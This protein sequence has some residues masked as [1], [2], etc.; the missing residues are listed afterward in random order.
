MPEKV[1]ENKLKFLKVLV[2]LLFI[3]LVS[4]LAY[5][6]LVQTQQFSTLSEQNRIRLVP[7]PAKRGE[8]L[9]H[10]GKV[11]V[12]DRPVYSVSIAY[13]GLKDQDPEK[14]AVKLAS[15]LGMNAR[16]IVAAVNDKNIRK[17]EPI[18]I[19]TDVPIDVVTKIEENRADL[20]GVEVNVEPMR[21]YVY[22]DFMPHALGYVREITPN[23]LKVHKDEGYSL[24]DRFGQAGL[25]NIY[26]KYLRGKDGDQQVEVD[27][28]QRPKKNLDIRSPIPGNNLVLNIDYK[29]Q[30]AAEE[31]L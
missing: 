7:I 13:L 29:V 31:S 12:K 18:K 21:E 6:Q 3:I 8:I 24:G 25:E 5:I 11:L 17:F 19:A 4:R 14:V 26:E 10:N 16:D 9:D 20:S 28:S 2:M 23:Q 27:K 30:K 22:K 15:I 1:V